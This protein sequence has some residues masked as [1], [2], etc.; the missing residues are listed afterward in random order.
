MISADPSPNAD[1]SARL[2]CSKQAMRALSIYT[3]LPIPPMGINSFSK[4]R[5]AFAQIMWRQQP[6]RRK[7]PCASSPL[8]TPYPF[9]SPSRLRSVSHGGWSHRLVSTCTVRGNSSYPDLNSFRFQASSSAS[10]SP[11]FTAGI[12]RLSSCRS[13]GCSIARKPN[14]RTPLRI[15]RPTRALTF[16]SDTE[17]KPRRGGYD[18]YRS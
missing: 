1:W 16:K 7:T 17:A 18:Q 9:F 13:T 5:I 15:S 12:S 2:S 11:T 14:A 4:Q 8:G 6:K 10:S 3:E